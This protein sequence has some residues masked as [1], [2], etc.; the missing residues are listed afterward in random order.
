MFAYESL[1][2]PPPARHACRPRPL[3]R[4]SQHSRRNQRPICCVGAAVSALDLH[5][6]CDGARAAWALQR[7]P[8]ILRGGS[9][10]GGPAFGTPTAFPPASLVHFPP[11]FDALVLMT[12][13]RQTSSEFVEEKNLS[14]WISVYKYRLISVFGPAAGRVQL[15]DNP[16]LPSPSRR[17]LLRL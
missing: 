12:K 5:S 11:C 17:T 4:V 3:H 10:R 2:T 1:R 9:D 7:G 16:Q 8:W 13:F 15:A 6:A 14:D